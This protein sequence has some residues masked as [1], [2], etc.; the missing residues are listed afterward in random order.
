[1][2][3]AKDPATGN[4]LYSQTTAPAETK[5]EWQTDTTNFVA[6]IDLPERPFSYELE[7]Y[8]KNEFT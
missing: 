8:A 7:F 6:W 5:I 2:I 3:V 1:M 4:T